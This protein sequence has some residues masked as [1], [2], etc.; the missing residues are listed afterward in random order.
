MISAPPGG[1]KTLK[2]FIDNARSSTAQFGTAG[3]GSASYIVTQYF[4]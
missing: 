2:E 1:A 3:A 4:L